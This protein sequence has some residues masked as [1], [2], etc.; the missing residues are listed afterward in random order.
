MHPKAIV[1]WSS[2]KDSAYALYELK[3]LK[4]F[5]IVGLVTTLTEEYERVSMHGTREA[6]LD[7]QA[8]R[9][10]LQIFKIKIP[11]PCSNEIYETKMQALITQLESLRVTHFIFGDLFLT[12]IR[13]YREKQ[14]AKTKIQPIFPLWERNTEQLSKQMISDEFKPI[15][16]CVDRSK[17]DASFSGRYYDEAFLQSLPKG[18]DPCGE[19]GEF[20]TVVVNCP[21]FDKPIDCKVGE[22]VDREGFV[23][24]D[25]IPT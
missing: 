19:N 8:Q 3:K 20:H 23:F 7:L 22:I 17:L 5:E 25:I 2:G 9:L 12:D 6:L 1:S 11:S 10:G 16:S 4:Q 21:L 13:A 24:A 14:L 15:I 18:V